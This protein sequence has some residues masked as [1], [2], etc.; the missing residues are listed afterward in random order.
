MNIHF[1]SEDDIR[2]QPPFDI[3]GE[4]YKF[5]FIADVPGESPDVLGDYDNHLLATRLERFGAVGSDDRLDCESCC[6]YIYFRTKQAGFNFITKL[7]AYLSQ[8]AQLL[9]EAATF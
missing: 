6:F 3:D 2:T 8:K 4:E 5:A 9:R 1:Y 7:N